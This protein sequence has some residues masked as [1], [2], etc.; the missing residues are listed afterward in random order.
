MGGIKLAKKLTT[1]ARNLLHL[2]RTVAAA[3]F[4]SD[5][6]PS[7]YEKPSGIC[8][9][10]LGTSNHCTNDHFGAPESRK[11]EKWCCSWAI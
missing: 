9:G 10:L 8:S 7:C 11:V 5:S 3:A 4:A 2:T 6:N 1:Q